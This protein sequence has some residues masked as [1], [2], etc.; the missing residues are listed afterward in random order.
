MNKVMEKGAVIKY[1]VK[2]APKT[3][4]W[5]YLHPEVKKEK[6]I[7]C[8]QCVPFCPEACIE[9]REEKTDSGIIKKKAQIDYDFCK[10]CGVCAAVCSVKAISMLKKDQ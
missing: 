3:G 10:G 1:D 9:L 6:C 8:G 7:G 4:N 5:R 2:K